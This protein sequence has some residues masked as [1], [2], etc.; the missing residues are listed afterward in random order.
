MLCRAAGYR[1]RQTDAAADLRLSMLGLG[2]ISLGGVSLNGLQQ[3]G[4]IEEE[5]PGGLERG[6]RLFHWPVTPWCSTFF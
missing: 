6:E 3:A 5:R 1:R 4:L 2:A